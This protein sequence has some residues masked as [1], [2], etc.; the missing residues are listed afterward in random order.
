[1]NPIFCKKVYK[2]RISDRIYFVSL[3]MYEYH[4]SLKMLIMKI[5]YTVNYMNVIKFIY[6]KLNVKM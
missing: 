3:L 5:N 1:M 6:I 2:F 4:K